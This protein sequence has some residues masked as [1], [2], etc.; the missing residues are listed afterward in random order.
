M[1]VLDTNA[2]KLFYLIEKWWMFFAILDE[3]KLPVFATEVFRSPHKENVSTTS[4]VS[5]CLSLLQEMD[6][7]N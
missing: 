5:L 3:K 2:A 6:Q 1:L 7:S 4:S